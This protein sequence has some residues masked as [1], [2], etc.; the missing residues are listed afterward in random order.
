VTQLVKRLEDLD[1]VRKEVRERE[2]QIIRQHLEKDDYE[3]AI[4]HWTDGETVINPHSP[5]DA[6]NCCAPAAIQIE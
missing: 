3:A 2:A 1:K 6:V 5:D 4:R